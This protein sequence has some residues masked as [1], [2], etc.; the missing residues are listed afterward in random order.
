M[1][2]GSI[3]VIFNARAGSASGHAPASVADLFRAAGSQ[4]EIIP[5]GEGESPT[6]AARAASA[7]AA[8]VVAA[9][10]DGTVSSVAAALVR[11]EAAL[12]VLP[13]GTLNHFAKDLH[14][15]LDVRDAV[16]V[17]A[18]GRVSRV[19]VGEVN[20]R[21]F[22]NNASIGIY[23][24]VVSEREQLRHQG[25]GKW[26]ATAAAV[27]RVFSRYRGVT[28]RIAVDGRER[29][30]RTPFVVAGNNRYEI[31]GI[32]LGSRARLDEGKLF[33]YLA[34]H[35]PVRELPLLV[36]TAL[37][38][39]AASSHAFEILTAD[40]VTIETRTARA[41]RLALDG[42]VAIMTTPLVYRARPRDLR[43]IVPPME[44]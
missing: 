1:A 31:D 27:V 41:I 8:I 7:R 26:R 44:P 24:S 17:I 32:G 6:D 20:E 4:A 2:A 13:L 23:P 43:V 34:P 28:V 25:Y 40:H 37:L 39:R 11:T 5:L 14:I 9:G 36:V 12:G 35:T 10:G 22:I 18:A 16:N 30:W 15:P 42:E 29:T 19:D 3:A 33:V 38:G 21:I